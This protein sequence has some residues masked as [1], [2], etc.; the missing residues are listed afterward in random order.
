MAAVLEYINTDGYRNQRAWKPNDDRRFTALV[1]CY[2]QLPGEKK[3]VI[4]KPSTRP[5]TFHEC[6]LLAKK[7]K[8]EY[9]NNLKQMVIWDMDE[10]NAISY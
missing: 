6:C 10:I 7:L 4:E 2:V 9:G 8:N 5:A 3:K 1:K